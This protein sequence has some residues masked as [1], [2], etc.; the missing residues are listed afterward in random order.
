MIVLHIELAFRF[1][2][3][4]NTYHRYASIVTHVLPEASFTK[5]QELSNVSTWQPHLNRV[6]RSNKFK[7]SKQFIIR[8][9]RL[10]G[11]LYR[12]F[13]CLSQ[14]FIAKAPP[15]EHTFLQ[16]HLHAL[17]RITSR[18]FTTQR[19]L[20]LPQHFSRLYLYMLCRAALNLP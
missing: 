17:S 19:L 9:T 5:L 13:R 6:L 8:S 7:T 11:R 2:Q 12:K 3:Q 1:W 15:T 4:T 16:Q 14:R 18:T 10:H 20:R